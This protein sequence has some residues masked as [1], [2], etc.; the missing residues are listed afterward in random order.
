MNTL[1]ITPVNRIN[2]TK[3]TTSMKS[4][5][6]DEKGKN[7]KKTRTQEFHV[8]S[9]KKEK[10]QKPNDRETFHI[11]TRRNKHHFSNSTSTLTITITTTT[12]PTTTTTT[13]IASY[14][15]SRGA[16]R[17]PE[18]GKPPGEQLNSLH[19]PLLYPSRSE[20]R[21]GQHGHQG[22]KSR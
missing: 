14:R 7:M 17:R 12:T 3:R 15:S 8:K 6:I 20:G 10:S 1:C 18:H 4:E 9:L 19:L 5:P 22:S 2:Q 13:I 11:D 21:R 16:H